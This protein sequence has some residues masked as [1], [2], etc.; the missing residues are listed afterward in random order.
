MLTN[1]NPKP[2]PKDAPVIITRPSEQN[3]GL[4]N[5]LKNQGRS[6][7]AMPLIDIKPISNEQIKSC[8]LNLDNYEFAFPVSANAV[9][10]AMQWVDSYWPQTPVGLKW[11]AVGPASKQALE[12]HQIASADILMPKDK[13]ASEGLLELDELQTGYTNKV[14]VLRAETG[15]SLFANSLK[16]RG[17]E[18]EIL[19]LYERLEIEHSNDAWLEALKQP[20]I[21][22]INSSQT[23]EAAIKQQ[24]KLGQKALGAL[25]PSPRIASEAKAYFNQV[26]V[27]RSA[28]DEHLLEMLR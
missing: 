26:W 14:L 16:E 27:S 13:Y 1:Q 8:F 9:N 12:N 2:L 7:F 19:A 6:V 24:P 25:V 4:I 11:L 17:F 18:V 5:T 15:R 23:L 22:Q 21:V 3:S 28:T 20:A 10:I